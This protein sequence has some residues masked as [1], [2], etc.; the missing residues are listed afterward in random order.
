MEKDTYFVNSIFSNIDVLVDGQFVREQ[1]DPYISYR[2]SRN[3]RPID[4]QASLASK[5][6]VM[7]DWDSPEIVIDLSGNAFMPIGLVNEFEELGSS[8][9]TRRCGQTKGF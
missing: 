5:E 7:L 6:I 4:V 3:Q 8:D 9:I 1:D 2:G